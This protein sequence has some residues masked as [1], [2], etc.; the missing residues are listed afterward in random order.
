MYSSCAVVKSGG[1]ASRNARPGV[2]L[3]NSHGGSSVTHYSY[4]GPV[5]DTSPI[6][7]RRPH[8]LPFI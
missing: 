2:E 7:A 3:T 4:A 6:N 8:S 1:S 5:A